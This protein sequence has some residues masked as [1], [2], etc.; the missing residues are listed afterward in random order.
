M[1]V[2]VCVGPRIYCNCHVCTN[3]SPSLFPA[4]L[5]QEFDKCDFSAI[6][7]HLDLQKA[8]KK[9]TQPQKENNPQAVLKARRKS[10]ALEEARKYSFAGRPEPSQWYP[11]G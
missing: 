8:L 4:L 1:S 3:I 7:T 5:S 10:K 6:R 9:A 11:R 2:G